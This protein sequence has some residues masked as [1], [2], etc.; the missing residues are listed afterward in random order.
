MAMF[1]A[2]LILTLPIYSALAYASLSY[3]RVYGV[4]NVN[5]YVREY[6]FTEVVA[7]ANILGDTQIDGTQLKLGG[8]TGFTCTASAAGS[9]N[10]ECTI[11]NPATGTNHYTSATVPLTVLLYNDG[12]AETNRVNPNAVVDRLAPVVKQFTATPALTSTGTVIL[13]YR[14]ED[15]SY[16]SG[17]TSDCSGLKSLDIY[18]NDFS[19][20]Q[21]HSKILDENSCTE[22]GQVE[23][24]ATT[25]GE[26]RLC[27]KA[28]DRL[29]HASTA[30]KCTTFVYDTT[31]PAYVPDTFSITKNSQPLEF[32]GSQPITVSLSITL[33]DDV[34]PATVRAD[35]S[36]LN[37]L[38]PTSYAN[39]PATCSNPV[40]N[41]ITCSWSNVQVRLNAAAS[42]SIPITFMD[43][44]VPPNEGS[45]SLPL[46]L[47]FD[48]QGPVIISLQSEA[49]LEGSNYA[50]ASG[51]NFTAEI[52]D[53]AGVRKEDMR[54]YVGSSMSYP[55]TRCEKTSNWICHWDNID[56][57]APD[58]ST[59]LV[60]IDTDSKDVLGNH[61]SERKEIEVIVD[62]RAPVVDSGGIV[63]TPIGVSQDAVAGFTKFGDKV[64]I[65]VPV[66]DAGPI[67][68]T[69]DLS[70]L[71]QGE[72]NVAITTCTLQ[73]ADEWTCI[74]SPDQGINRQGAAE[75]TIRLR[76]EDIAGNKASVDV[77][78]RVLGA[79]SEAANKFYEAEFDTSR[80]PPID[81]QVLRNMAS[82]NYYQ[83]I[84]LKLK[85]IPASCNSNDIE[86][87]NIHTAG[88][89]A[90]TRPIL[91]KQ[92]N[93]YSGFV[94][95][96]VLRTDIGP[97]FTEY[98]ISSENKECYLEYNIRCGEDFFTVPE[99]LELAVNVPI[100]ESQ[101]SAESVINEIEDIKSGINDFDKLLDALDKI[102]KFFKSMCGLKATFAALLHMW[103]LLAKGP[104][105]CI[106]TKVGKIVSADQ[107]NTAEK[108]VRFSKGLT[109]ISMKGAEH[110]MDT[111][112][113][114]ATC[115]SS[116]VDVPVINKQFDV[117]TRYCDILKDAIL[118]NI[119]E[120][121]GA[122]A[123]GVY[124]GLTS[125][126]VQYYEQDTL[127]IA[128]KSFAF[129]V[130]CGCVPGVI[131]NIRKFQ[132][133]DCKKGV[134]LRDLV[135]AGVPKSECE[136]QNNYETC[137]Y[138]AGQTL[139]PSFFD[140]IIAQPIKSI[141]NA[142]DNPVATSYMIFKIALEKR[143]VGA[144]VD[145]SVLNE[146]AKSIEDVGSCF[147]H[148]T[149]LSSSCVL[150]S[151]LTTLETAAQIAGYWS[152]DEF[153]LEQEVNYCDILQ[154]DTLQ[155]T[156]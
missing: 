93:D 116:V 81:R 14:V 64:Q 33:D 7:T 87:A 99:Q 41:Q 40:Q 24:T 25:P 113:S 122:T 67:R 95:I 70:Q 60:W 62:K 152:N 154:Q 149:S 77:P 101:D 45:A 155:Q 6:D 97:G 109:L 5:G 9:N 120:K 44:A 37:T 72:A 111:A 80:L 85:Y 54:L 133:I 102:M 31:A 27:A 135:P 39:M 71:I 127:E 29:N 114:F 56:V 52:T 46:T 139:I 10:F 3:V 100:V 107:C 36:A 17:D 84:P 144:D 145:T 19:G 57:G 156:Q 58:R 53:D 18:E 126:D 38:T 148:W 140:I 115:R 104:A 103:D 91:A 129:S 130:A 8:I 20:L 76:I 75:R 28:I 15:Y 147:I 49:N 118:T 66:S 13:N 119:T 141:M 68:G 105:F 88:T 90:G 123:G 117:G 137:V 59:L 86:I 94:E 55:A 22:Q 26:V 2:V 74:W 50:K 79:V 82:D 1:M 32:A 83:P 131:Y 65:Q 121:L 132:Q 69:A 146:C 89:C 35:L 4:D 21:V 78:V 143:C 92:Q 73:S 47:G 142:I 34:D 30:L 96:P 61:V 138:W 112:C 42:L 106:D 51:N 151:A 23:Y 63:I 128:K 43:K 12:G 136:K 11:R 134:C 124:K 108:A 48:N 153:K 16:S 125:R 98:P 150:S 110:F